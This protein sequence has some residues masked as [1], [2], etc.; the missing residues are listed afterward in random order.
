MLPTAKS[1]HSEEQV[2]AELERLD[3]R[4]LSRQFESVPV[5]LRAPQQLLADLVRQPSS[6]VRA[7]LIALLL[8]HPE[9]AAHVESALGLLEKEHA[10]TFKF[11]YTAAV[12]L[13]KQ[14]ENPLRVFM[15]TRFQF[16]PDLYSAQLG[17][18]GETPTA[19]LQSLA[20]IHIQANGVHL[21]WAGTYQSAAQHLLRRWEMERQWNQ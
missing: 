3:V 13:Q 15:G 14:F 9:Y 2:I 17:V 11:F 20:K 6:R 18:T 19:R 10:Q 7:A 21:N 16:L 5:E 12:Y 1:P 8:A 4:Y